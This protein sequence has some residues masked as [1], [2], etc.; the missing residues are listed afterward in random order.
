MADD[1]LSGRQKKPSV[2]GPIMFGGA[3][4]AVIIGFAV[5]HKA[6]TVAVTMFC[7]GITLLGARIAQLI[8]AIGANK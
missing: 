8:V 7:Y 6:W 3:V 4:Y 1:Q 2:D 5:T